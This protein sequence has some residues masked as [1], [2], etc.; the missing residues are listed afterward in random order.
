MLLLL[1]LPQLLLLSLA[2]MVWMWRGEAT[3]PAWPADHT[4]MLKIQDLKGNRKQC[5]GHDILVRIRI[6]IR[7]Q[8][9]DRRSL[10]DFIMK[11]AVLWIRVVY[12]R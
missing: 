4:E 8:N 1:L 5:S 2:S 11:A 6:R 12:P 10:E 9:T 3:T 7:N